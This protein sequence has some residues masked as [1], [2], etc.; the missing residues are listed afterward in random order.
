MVGIL[1]RERVGLGFKLERE[2]D[3]DSSKERV[4]LVF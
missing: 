2:E 4:W 3:W 1:I